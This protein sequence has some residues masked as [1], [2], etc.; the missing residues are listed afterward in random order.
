MLDLN[1]GLAQI[2]ITSGKGKDRRAMGQRGKERIR[3]ITQE[4]LPEPGY[5]EDPNSPIN[6]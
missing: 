1:E 2:L 5:P 3:P 6:P 4:P